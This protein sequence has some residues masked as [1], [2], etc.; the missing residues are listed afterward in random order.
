M[1]FPRQSNADR[2]HRQK[3]K[4]HLFIPPLRVI[5][6][7]PSA[8][9]FFILSILL[10][11]VPGW[12][13][14]TVEEAVESFETSITKTRSLCHGILKSVR[15]IR[16]NYPEESLDEFERGEALGHLARTREMV[17]LFDRA[18]DEAEKLKRSAERALQ[19][20]GADLVGS[21]ELKGRIQDAARQLDT[22]HRYVGKFYGEVVGIYG[23]PPAPPSVG[24]APPGSP[25]SYAPPVPPGGGEH[26]IHISG[27]I[28]SALGHSSYKR[29]HEE[30]DPVDNSTT[31][32]E[33]RLNAGTR[34]SS[35]TV[36]H[37]EIGR[38]NKVERE[39]FALT[40]AGFRA[41]H[42]FPAGWELGGGVGYRGYNE[43][44][45]DITDY[46]ETNMD[47]RVTF[48]GPGPKFRAGIERR[49]RSFSDKKVDCDYSVTTLTAEGETPVGHGSLFTSLSR[50]ENDSQI[51]GADYSIF[52]PVL[53]WRTGRSGNEVHFSLEQF[54][55]DDESADH[56]RMKGHLRLGR[57]SG[58]SYSYIGPEVQHYTFP[59]VD[60]AGYT[61]FGFAGRGSGYSGL[62]EGGGQRHRHQW[63]VYFRR[64]RAEDGDDFAGFSWNSRRTPRS[65][66]SLREFGLAGTFYVEREEY[67]SLGDVGS[68]PS[69]EDTYIALGNVVDAFQSTAP[70]HVLD[71]HL[72]LG[73]V[74]R[75]WPEVLR[76]LEISGAVGHALFADTERDQLQ[77]EADDLV[78]LLPD[79]LQNVA[80]L[81]ETNF[82]FGNSINRA[83]W[84][85]RTAAVATPISR[86]RGRASIEYSQEV[87]YNA[88][89]VQRAAVFDL[90]LSGDC[91]FRPDLFLE[92][93]VEHHSTTI[94]SGG[95]PGDLNRSELTLR[96]RYMFNAMIGRRTAASGGS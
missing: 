7:G 33:G 77:Q 90:Q 93:C 20:G 12:T 80:P 64:Q 47:A 16:E 86:V 9:A 89:P 55:A 85:I 82:L 74:I 29:P 1:R 5:F 58:R 17:G 60:E 71:A 79:S 11:P 75:P 28:L 53:T 44:D 23:E 72:R 87:Y 13:G 68:N 26:P 30:P 36:L 32:F 51:D 50:M 45:A 4:G 31:L 24:P 10:H 39:A 34:L 2:S 92:A 37:A 78:E 95:S 59:N 18:R 69:L 76:S 22:Y 3:R 42:S 52:Q 14:S 49:G 40:S 15:H 63:R 43:K 6:F 46:G 65:S 70:P 35:G 94:G 21:V 91:R 67:D 25:S 48:T 66:G 38:E 62:T 57:Q 81:G 19:E 41:R 27:E 96:L 54:R 83:R 88:D 61:D 73:R 8:Y 84:G 56:N